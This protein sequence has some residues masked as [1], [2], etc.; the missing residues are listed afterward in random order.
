MNEAASV[1]ETV[2]DFWFGTLSEEGRADSAHLKSWFTKDP[3]FDAT[4]RDRFS[5]VYAQL[6][7][8]APLTP[9]WLREGRD[10]LAAIIVLDQFSRNMFRDTPA[11][12]SADPLA[13]S[14]AFELI[15][16]GEDRTLPFSMRGFSYMPLMHS[17]SLAHQERCIELFQAFC[18]ELTGEKRST[19]EY[20]LEFA[21]K[22]R[23]I[24]ARFGRFPHRN[25]ILGRESTEEEVEF[26]AGPGSRF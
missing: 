20:N 12:F 14:H 8:R 4:I 19:I 10:R 17:E 11:M 1:P 6:V 3:E 22:H 23:D 15:G 21:V 2:L 5:W 13:R 16:L 24:I 26:L 25:A 7:G 18:D 9:E